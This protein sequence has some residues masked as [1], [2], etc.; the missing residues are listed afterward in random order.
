MAFI[1]R[2]GL[3]LWRG[4]IGSSAK[5]NESLSRVDVPLNA[6]ALLAFVTA[7]EPHSTCNV[8]Y[9][10]ASFWYS[11]T[12]GAPGT[13]SNI[14]RKGIIYFRDPTDL[15]VK[16]FCYP[17]PVAADIEDTPWGKKIKDS[18]V[19]AIVALLS[20]MTGI[21]YEPM[22]GMYYQRK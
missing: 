8:N 5:D 4:D 7:V 10:L 19:V 17:D 11:Q 22:Y 9:S 14:D 15:S 18:A 16:P 20:T 12:A 3:L 6:S 1:K 13:G 2:S 21:S